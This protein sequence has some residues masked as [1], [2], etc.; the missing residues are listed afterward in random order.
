MDFTYGDCKKEM[1]MINKAFIET[2][3]EGDANG[4][5]FQYPIPTYSITKDF[6]WSDTENNRLLFEMTSKYGTPYFSNY[7]NSDMQPSDVAEHVLP[8]APGSAGA[9]QKDRRLLRFRREH[10]L[11][12][13]CDDQYSED[14][15]SCQR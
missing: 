4:R 1:D 10:R 11:C 2:M 12:G 9:A 5:G 7:I 15:I 13:R 3:I 14:R 6:D 8:S